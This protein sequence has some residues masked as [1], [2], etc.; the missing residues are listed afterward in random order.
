MV[1]VLS[2]FVLTGKG[3]G[4]GSLRLRPCSP[5]HLGTWR[6]VRWPADGGTLAQCCWNRAG[7]GENTVGCAVGGAGAGGRFRRGGRGSRKERARSKAEEVTVH[8][9][10]GLGDRAGTLREATTG[11]FSHPLVRKQGRGEGYT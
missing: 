1:K 2:V 4:E 10:A 3:E 7:P 9:A 11:E 5:H 8:R 6:G